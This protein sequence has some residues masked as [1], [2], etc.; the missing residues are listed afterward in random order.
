MCTSQSNHPYCKSMGVNL[1][2]YFKNLH[3]NNI[4]QGDSNKIK[5]KIVKKAIK[6]LLQISGT[7]PPQWNAIY[8]K[9]YLTI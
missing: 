9:L 2:F 8:L 5:T 7:N 6:S 1:S 3:F 4:P